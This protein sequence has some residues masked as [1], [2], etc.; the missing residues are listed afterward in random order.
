MP[1]QPEAFIDQALRVR[2]PLRRKT[3]AWRLP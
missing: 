3:E 2:A 1:E